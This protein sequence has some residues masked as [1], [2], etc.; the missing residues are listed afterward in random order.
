MD[1]N[2]CARFLLKVNSET[3]TVLVFCNVF[4]DSLNISKQGHENV[5]IYVVKPHNAEL[6]VFVAFPVLR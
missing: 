4:K 6:T 2:L 1:F 3:V 5:C